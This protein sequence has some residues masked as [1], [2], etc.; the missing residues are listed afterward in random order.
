METK[1][2]SMHSYI[3]IGFLL[4]QF[5]GRNNYIKS[6]YFFLV[7]MVYVLLVYNPI[8]FNCTQ[9]YNFQVSKCVCKIGACYE[10][11]AFA[12]GGEECV[13]TDITDCIIKWRKCR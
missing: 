13:G 5:W 2:L 8:N 4:L 11:S 7:L 12:S 6:I 3:P 1:I 9:I 10:A